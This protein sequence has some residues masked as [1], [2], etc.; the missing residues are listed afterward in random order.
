MIDRA[1]FNA[2]PLWYE[3]AEYDENGVCGIRSD[4]PEDVK[5]EVDQYFQDLVLLL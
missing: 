4:A 1:P 2:R 5:K 3:Y